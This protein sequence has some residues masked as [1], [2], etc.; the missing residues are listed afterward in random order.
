MNRSL[1][2]A[3]LAAGLALGLA[4]CGGQAPGSLPATVAQ[5]ARAPQGLHGGCQPDSYGYCYTV[6]GTT[7]AKT[8]C[9]I[10]GQVSW[11]SRTITTY[12][13][14]DPDGD[15]TNYVKTVWPACGAA[16]SYTTWSPDEPRAAT[17]DPNLP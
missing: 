10:N 8:S 16:L 4:A 3:S 17:G 15:S 2:T 14:I 5:Q 9:T 12:Q 13:V 11:P 6:T 1:R 7:Y